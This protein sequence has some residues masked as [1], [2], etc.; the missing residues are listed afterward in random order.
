MINRSET[1]A[2]R[3]LYQCSFLGVSMNDITQKFYRDPEDAPDLRPEDFMARRAVI[4]QVEEWCDEMEEKPDLI[5]QNKW[6][7]ILYLYEVSESVLFES[8]RFLT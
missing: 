4:K 8:S 5:Y 1:C 7:P 3:R 2:T 6:T